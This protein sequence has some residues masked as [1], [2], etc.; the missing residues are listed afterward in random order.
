MKN[1]KNTNG[2][3]KINTYYKFKRF[4]LL[5]NDAVYFPEILKTIYFIL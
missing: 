1:K 3:G 5:E 2:F 4:L